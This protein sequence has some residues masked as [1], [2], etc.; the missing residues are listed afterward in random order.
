M[1]VYGANVMLAESKYKWPRTKDTDWVKVT[2]IL[3]IFDAPVTTGRA[4]R[5]VYAQKDVVQFIESQT[6]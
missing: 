1:T 4:G 3:L 6:F 5:M 2:G